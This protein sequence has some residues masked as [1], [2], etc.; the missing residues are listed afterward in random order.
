MDGSTFT[1]EHFTGRRSR[2]DPAP[3]APRCMHHKLA[4]SRRG[5]LGRPIQPDCHHTN[6]ELSATVP[7]RGIAL[8]RASHRR[9]DTHRQT[10]R[11]TDRETDRQIDRHTGTGSDET[12]Q[13]S[14]ERRPGNGAARVPVSVGQKLYPFLFLSSLS[15][16]RPWSWETGTDNSRPGAES[17]RRRNRA[18]AM[19]L[20]ALPHNRPSVRSARHRP[21]C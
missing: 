11:Y 19:A 15:P 8:Y 16:P 3:L 4:P 14:G 20:A 13:E 12:C 17:Q 1:G 7:H 6:T 21:G 9:T 5:S 2:L 18:A 10:D